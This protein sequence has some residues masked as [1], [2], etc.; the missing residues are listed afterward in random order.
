MSEPSRTS[1]SKVSN[2]F[3][4]LGRA[5]LPFVP[6]ILGVALKFAL[7]DTPPADVAKHFFDTY[8]RP[9]WIEFLVTAYVMGVAAMLSG[10]P[11]NR[12][13]IILFIAVPALCFVA[14]LVLV[15]GT[16]KAGIDSP[17]MQVYIP[18]VIAAASLGI[19]G[20]RIGN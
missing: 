5:A 16:A 3:V 15:A 19:S 4:A 12:T 6:V 8:L 10:K 9:A 20:G 2:R 18:A 11:L 14:C 17:L 13:D 7:V 1:E